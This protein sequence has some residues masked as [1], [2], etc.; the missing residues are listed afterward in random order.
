MLVRGVQGE[1]EIV[2]SFRSLNP[3]EITAASSLVIYQDGKMVPSSEAEFTELEKELK[4][5]AL[6]CKFGS[7]TDCVADVRTNRLKRARENTVALSL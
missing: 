1:G 3:F 7:C 5:R 4:K 2:H 6:S